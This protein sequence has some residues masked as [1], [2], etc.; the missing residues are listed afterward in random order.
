MNVYF[1]VVKVDMFHYYLLPYEH[2]HFRIQ[3]K[4]LDE[5]SLRFKI[6]LPV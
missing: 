1:V 4:Q 5:Y 3:A 6:E 2:S